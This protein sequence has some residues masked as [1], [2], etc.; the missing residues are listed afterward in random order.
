ML[1][2]QR[3]IIYSTYVLPAFRHLKTGSFIASDYY[4]RITHHRSEIINGNGTDFDALHYCQSYHT[5][6]YFFTTEPMEHQF[7]T[8]ITI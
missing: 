7:K 8:E 2:L 3:R 4:H 1:T 6:Q 5:V